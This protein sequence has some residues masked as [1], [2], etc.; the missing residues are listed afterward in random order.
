MDELRAK[1]RELQNSVRGLSMEVEGLRVHTSSAST[2]ILDELES[3]TK[4]IN[5]L[6]NKLR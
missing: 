2:F 5:E 6:I 1:V 4:A 3:L